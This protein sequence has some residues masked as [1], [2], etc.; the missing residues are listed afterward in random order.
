MTHTTLVAQKQMP[1]MRAQ[2]ESLHFECWVH[3]FPLEFVELKSLT[4]LSMPF[5][6]FTD[7]PRTLTQL[8]NLQ[9]LKLGRAELS[10]GS[11]GDLDASALGDLSAFPC[12]QALEFTLCYVALAPRMGTHLHATLQQLVFFNALPRVTFGGPG[13]LALH[14]QLTALGRPGVLFTGMFAEHGDD[15]ATWFM[16]A[17]M[18]AAP[19]HA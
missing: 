11:V 6:C 17:L 9:E 3:S 4:V 8:S 7:L 13:V 18:M 12:L 2:L 19:P 1:M 14:R 5:L 10:D 15:S 16:Q